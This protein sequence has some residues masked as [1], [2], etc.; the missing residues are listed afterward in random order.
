MGWTD[1]LGHHCFGVVYAF[2]CFGCFW[3]R[4]GGIMD[5]MI[6]RDSIALPR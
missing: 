1:F 5:F 6:L 2:D 3:V 4:D